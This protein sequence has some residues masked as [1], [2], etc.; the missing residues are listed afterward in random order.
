[1]L[2]EKIAENQ[3]INNSSRA[4]NPDNEPQHQKYISSLE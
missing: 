3:T 4:A 1:M 2:L